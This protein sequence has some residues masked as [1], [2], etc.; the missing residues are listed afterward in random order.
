MKEEYLKHGVTTF[1]PTTVTLPKEAL[2][3]ACKAVGEVQDDSIPGM[4]LEGP[5][6]NE[7]YAGAQDTKYIRTPD[8][9]EVKQCIELSMNK[10]KTITLAPEKGLEYIDSLTALGIHVFIGHTDADYEVA[11]RAFP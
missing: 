1:L 6:I 10:V 7:K 5:F 3:E 9:S 11:S 2:L 4:H 8:L